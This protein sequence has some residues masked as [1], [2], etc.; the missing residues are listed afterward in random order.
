MGDHDYFR[1]GRVEYINISQVQQGPQE[2]VVSMNNVQEQGAV[3]N[4]DVDTGQNPASF[5]GNSSLASEEAIIA[6]SRQPIPTLTTASF[7]GNSPLA[8]E[9]AIIAGS[10]QPT[11]TTA[12]FSSEPQQSTD[13]T[14]AIQDLAQVAASQG[15]VGQGGAGQNTDLGAGGAG[16][17]TIGVEGIPP[18]DPDYV[19]NQP[20]GAGPNPGLGAGPNPGLGAGPNLGLGA[21][22][23]PGGAA[24]AVVALPPTDPN[25]LLNKP[26][27]YDG[28]LQ[29][30]KKKQKVSSSGYTYTFHKKSKKSNITF[31]DCE[32]YRSGRC[33]GRIHVADGVVCNVVHDHTHAPDGARATVLRVCL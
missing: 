3:G 22:P 28:D 26:V 23:N 1:Y 5:G 24:I 12:S 33:N 17:H 4:V 8:S 21:G 10:R 11:P 6:E 18:A 25:D 16:D 7:G 9:E 13:S 31:W 19:A 29:S 30:Q 20:V 2:P 14:T 15:Y 32:N 27:E